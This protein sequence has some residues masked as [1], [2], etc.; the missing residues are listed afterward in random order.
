MTP[1]TE[2][3]VEFL[4]F[5]NLPY[6]RV[7]RNGKILFRTPEEEDE[8]TKEKKELKVEESISFFMSNMDMQ[9]KGNY[10]LIARKASKGLRGEMYFNFH[11]NNGH[12]ETQNNQL[13]VAIHGIGEIQKL[14]EDKLNFVIEAHKKDFEKQMIEFKHMQEIA[15]LKR[16]IKEKESSGTDLIGLI[17]Q[18]IPMI[19]AAMPNLMPAPIAAAVANANVSG[20]NNI[21][22]DEAEQATRMRAALQKLNNATGGKLTESL[23][24]LV[25][26]SETEP[27]NFTIML[28]HLEN[29]K[30]V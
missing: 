16:Q 17:Q 19:Q 29:G 28:N 7:M 9:E 6:F 8:E 25:R 1:T 2:T 27:M 22:N 3:A 5:N 26:Y 13:P 21:S 10:V 15:E 14:H 11:N 12:S 23:E 18:C 4:K 20:T 24:N 30:A